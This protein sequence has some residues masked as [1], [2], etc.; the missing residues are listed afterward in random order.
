MLILTCY[1]QI[2]A[3]LESLW[4]KRY[5]HDTDYG[6]HK[7]TFIASPRT[8][9]TEADK[10]SSVE[11]IDFMMQHFLQDAILNMLFSLMLSLNLL[12]LLCL[13]IL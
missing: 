7:Q 4:N 10:N 9:Y 6:I 1:C 3:S 2:P 8:L 13:F 12:S 5:G 11:L